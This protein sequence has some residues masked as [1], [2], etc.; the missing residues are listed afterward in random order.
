M[1]GDSVKLGYLAQ[2]AIDLLDSERTASD[3]L[4]AGLPEPT[5]EKRPWSIRSNGFADL[6][7]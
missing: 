3:T 4:K 6:P 7:S 2:D 5:A 1:L